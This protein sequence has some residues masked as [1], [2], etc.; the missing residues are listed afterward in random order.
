M[1]TTDPARQRRARLDQQRGRFAMVYVGYA[2]TIVL[3]YV[4]GLGVMSLVGLMRESMLLPGSSDDDS[5]WLVMTMVL[6]F[7][8]AIVAVTTARRDKV[9]RARVLASRLPGLVGWVAFTVATFVGESRWRDPAVVG[10]SPG[11]FDEDPADP[12]GFDSWFLYRLDLL[13]YLSVAITLLVAWWWWRTEQREGQLSADRDRLLASG[14]Q[15]TGTITEAKI[16]HS[17]DDSGSRRVTGA[18]ATVRFADASGV[19]RWVTRRTSDASG[20]APGFPAQVLFDPMAPGDLER[21]FVAFLP[22]PDPS[23]WIPES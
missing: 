7:V 12:W 1:S 19:D 21:I 17:T 11:F 8:A 5:P 14:R 6:A 15:V 18:T 23:D 20:I 4:G 13:P 22:D 3:A 10:E 16:H 2:L 9:A